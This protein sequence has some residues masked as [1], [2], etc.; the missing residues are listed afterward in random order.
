MNQTTGGRQRIC[1]PDNYQK[2]V[3]LVYRIIHLLLFPLMQYNFCHQIIFH[4]FSKALKSYSFTFHLQVRPAKHD[5]PHLRHHWGWH[6]RYSQGDND[7]NSSSSMIADDSIIVTLCAKGVR[8]RLQ[9][10]DQ[11]IFQ[12]Q[13]ERPKTAGQ[14]RLQQGGTSTRGDL[15]P[16]SPSSEFSWLWECFRTK[17][18]MCLPF[19]FPRPVLYSVAI[20][21]CCLHF[22]KRDT[23][24]QSLTFS[25]TPKNL[26]HIL[27]PCIS[28]LT[29][30][31][32]TK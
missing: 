19:R 14:Q 5:R 11:C 23:K 22:Y 18:A 13:V 7:S 31:T 25:D 8:P 3:S 26:P 15:S 4:I 28:L 9:H 24:D 20:I 21:V 16:P 27:S 2:L 1:V 6:Q 17:V 12:C 29:S 32:W 10:H 30:E